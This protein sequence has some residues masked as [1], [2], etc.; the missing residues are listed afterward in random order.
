MTNIFEKIEPTII[1]TSERTSFLFKRRS[2]SIRLADH[3]QDQTGLDKFAKSTLDFG[4]KGL[5]VSRSQGLGV[6]GKCQK[7]QKCWG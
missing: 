5:K 6:R 7:C 2:Y 4:A 3:K 1:F